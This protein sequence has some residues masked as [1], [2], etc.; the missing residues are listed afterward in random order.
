MLSKME[1]TAS[2]PRSV[3][4][5]GNAASLAP[6]QTAP[7]SLPGG[8]T[9]CAGSDRMCAFSRSTTGAHAF[10]SAISSGVYPGG[11]PG[12]TPSTLE[13]VYGEA[14]YCSSSDASSV[15]PIDAA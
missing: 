4:H 10:A 3:N 5:I 15:L 12:S 8:S 11:P 13:R 2:K 9:H 1:S 7:R 6:S 14:L